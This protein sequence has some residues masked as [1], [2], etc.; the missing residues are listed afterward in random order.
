[1][2]TYKFPLRH[3]DGLATGSTLDPTLSDD[4]I[5][6][7]SLNRA[8]SHLP[9]VDCT[10]D[11]ERAHMEFMRC[12]ANP[13]GVMASGGTTPDLLPALVERINPKRSGARARD[14]DPPLLRR[15]NHP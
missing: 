2:V 14:A 10:A 9:W 7:L 8:C 11:P 5:V 6:L 13:F 12:I 4:L 3:R 1:M 15:S